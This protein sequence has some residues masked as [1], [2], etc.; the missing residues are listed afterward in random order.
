MHVLLLALALTASPSWGRFNLFAGGGTSQIDDRG[1]SHYELGA[2][3]Q[4]YLGGLLDDDT[5]MAYQPLEQQLPTL[6][7]SGWYD[8]S[9]ADQ[10]DARELGGSISGTAFVDRS[11]GVSAALSMEGLHEQL[12]SRS[13]DFV[14]PDLS[15]AV[16]GAT[17]TERIWVGVELEQLY[18]NGTGWPGPQAFISASGGALLGERVWLGLGVGTLRS[19]EYANATAEV[20]P[21]HGTDLELSGYAQR[22][23]IYIDTPHTFSRVGGD[24]S[25]A[26]WLRDAMRLGLTYGL[27]SARQDL[28]DRQSGD[29]YLVQGVSL[30]FGLRLQ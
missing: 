25:V 28:G 27:S 13:A 1:G 19:G 2:S 18:V 29:T 22:G 3:Q 26:I 30:S 16:G 6:S 4:L 8:L 14:K 20:A 12:G 21:T 17:P 7:A 15:L 24:A 10:Y 5:P 9:F 23:Q 11:I